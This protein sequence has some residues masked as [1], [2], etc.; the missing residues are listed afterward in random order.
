MPGRTEGRGPIE[1]ARNRC[2]CGH[3]P[4][5]HMRVVPVAESGSFRLEPNGPCSLC[6]EAACR[7]F[8]PGL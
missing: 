6:G 5:S 1:A 4:T 8:T 3:Y 7:Q 2:R